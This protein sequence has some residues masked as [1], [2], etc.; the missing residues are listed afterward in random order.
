MPT[1]ADPGVFINMDLSPDG[2]GSR[3]HRGRRAGWPDSVDIWVAGLK[4]GTG[5]TR[6]TSEADRD[7][8]PSW[9]PDGS[10]I[11]YHVCRMAEIRFIP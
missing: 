9:S 5:S 3:C 1:S 11:A 4:P 2:Q 8:D 7:F 6:L 10:Y